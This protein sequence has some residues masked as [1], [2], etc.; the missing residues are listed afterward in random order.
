M[1][2][3]NFKASTSE[4]DGT[5][6]DLKSKTNKAT[7]SSTEGTPFH[8]IKDKTSSS[9]ISGIQVENSLL[10]KLPPSM[11]TQ[12]L[13]ETIFKMPKQ[14]SNNLDKKNVRGETPLHV[15]TIKVKTFR[16]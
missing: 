5:V 10:S 2:F 8:R 14:T 4:K 6:Q 7:V 3:L 12:K 1:L 9:L 11:R 13:D 15:A 16:S